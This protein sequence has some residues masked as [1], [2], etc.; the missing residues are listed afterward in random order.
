MGEIPIQFDDNHITVNEMRIFGIVDLP[1]SSFECQIGDETIQ[2]KTIQEVKSSIEAGLK[3]LRRHIY[4]SWHDLQSV[5]DI[6]VQ[7]DSTNDG[8]LDN[9]Y[10]LHSVKSVYRLVTRFTDLTDIA[11]SIRDV[12][13]VDV[14]NIH[15]NLINKFNRL[16]L[17]IKLT[18]HL[19]MREIYRLKL[20]GKFSSVHKKAQVSGPWA[21]LD[22]PMKERVWEWSEESDYMDNRS[23]ARQEQSR[24]NPEYD[25]NGFYYVWQDHTRDPYLF[26]DM[27]EDS[28]YKSNSYTSIP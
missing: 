5:A 24:Y 9:I 20:I 21:N 11:R 4:D 12:L 15:T 26:D 14:K 28:P 27:K 25:Q 2:A 23:R 7:N 8:A 1:D 16:F 17:S 19:I 10:F 22:L 13:F 6:I 3:E 18:H